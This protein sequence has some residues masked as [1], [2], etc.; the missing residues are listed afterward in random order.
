MTAA[1]QTVII[2]KIYW[3]LTVWATLVYIF[4][5]FKMMALWGGILAITLNVQ[6]KE[7]KRSQVK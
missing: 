2:G 6:M 7:L 4:N 5:S 1:S 3:V